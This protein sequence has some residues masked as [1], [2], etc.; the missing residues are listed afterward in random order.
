MDNNEPLERHTDDS[1][2][3]DAWESLNLT[4]ATLEKVRHQSEY[5]EHARE[6]AIT[7]TH[8]QNG[9]LWLKEIGHGGRIS[10]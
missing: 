6:L 10:T 2:L 8:L 7:I 9:R 5:G 1:L 3:R 4:L